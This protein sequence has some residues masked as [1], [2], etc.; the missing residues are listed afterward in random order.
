MSPRT[1]LGDK[2][3]TDGMVTGRE[4]RGRSVADVASSIVSGRKK[5]GERFNY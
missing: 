2:E 3:D 1:T 4:F 5:S